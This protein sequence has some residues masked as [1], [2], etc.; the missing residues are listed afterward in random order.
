M[1]RHPSLILLLL[2]A[3]SCKT[4]SSG[5]K[6][7]DAEDVRADKLSYFKC[8]N[9]DLAHFRIKAV[10][11]IQ[12]SDFAPLPK[13]ELWGGFDHYVN[14]NA[15]RLANFRL[16]VCMQDDMPV[17]KRMIYSSEGDTPTSYMVIGEEQGAKVEGLRE[18]LFD[19]DYSKLDITFPVSKAF[20]EPLPPG[21]SIR[22]QGSKARPAAI[23]YSMSERKGVTSIQ[24][25]NVIE[26]GSFEYEEPIEINGKF[27]PKECK[28]DPADPD[29]PYRPDARFP[30]RLVQKTINRQDYEMKIIAFPPIANLTAGRGPFDNMEGFEYGYMCKVIV[31]DNNPAMGDQKGKPVTVKVPFQGIEWDTESENLISSGGCDHHCDHFWWWLKTPF[32]KYVFTSSNVE[33]KDGTWPALN[34]SEKVTYFSQTP[35]E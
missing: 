11:G 12:E 19:G 17:L 30:H 33:P 3:L 21:Y 5:S 27:L 7:K 23:V 15:E 8:E 22:I 35:P 13:V 14:R 4:S 32:A 28:V 34:E 18:L 26:A 31:T 1:L 25:R 6:V 20:G 10:D 2:A 24:G 29:R 9:G 16:E